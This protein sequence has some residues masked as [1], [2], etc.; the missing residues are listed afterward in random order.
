M[1]SDRPGITGPGG[2]C[3]KHSLGP[4]SKRVDQ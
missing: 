4:P 1:T 3:D 2:R